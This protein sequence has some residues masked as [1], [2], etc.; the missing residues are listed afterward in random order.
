MLTAAIDRY[1]MHQDG[2]AAHARLQNECFK[3]AIGEG[4]TATNIYSM[5]RIV[6]SD[7]GSTYIHARARDQGRSN[8]GLSRCRGSR[9]RSALIRSNERWFNT[10][11]RQAFWDGSPVDT[12]VR[13]N[14]D[15]MLA[16]D[17]GK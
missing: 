8:V 11:R 1:G 3:G 4:I 9:I 13:R 17:V 12:M 15:Y 2:P 7:T 10:V 6:G 14:V 16:Q 5:T